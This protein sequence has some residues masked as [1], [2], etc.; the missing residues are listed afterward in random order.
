MIYNV[1][2][3]VICYLLFPILLSPCFL[4]SV[5]YHYLIKDTYLRLRLIEHWFTL[6]FFL[7]SF[8]RKMWCHVLNLPRHLSL[9][10]WWYYGII[11]GVFQLR[12]WLASRQLELW[13]LN[14]RL[15]WLTTVSGYSLPC[16]SAYSPSL[17]CASVFLSILL[18]SPLP[19]LPLPFY[20]S[21]LPS[22]IIWSHLILYP[23]LSS[24]HLSFLLLPLLSSLLS[25]SPLPLLFFLLLSCISSSFL[26]SH[27][28]SYPV[29]SGPPFHSVLVPFVPFPH[30]LFC[31]CF[32]FP[33]LKPLLLSSALFPFI[34]FHSVWFLLLIY[35]HRPFSPVTLLSTMWST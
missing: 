14:N 25:Y 16:L 1:P 17:L 24:S 22:F 20:P 13:P 9:S 5:Y 23:F 27:L 11:Y 3:S 21:S 10:Q 29:P 31:C 28:F 7:C 6:H 26:L 15:L 32:I 19:S 4:S 30:L 8:A 33:L 34:L 18:C 35:S 2:G 12:S